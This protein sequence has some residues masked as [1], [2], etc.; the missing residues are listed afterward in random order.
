MNGQC[1]IKKYT[2]SKYMKISIIISVIFLHKIIYIHNMSMC[3]YYAHVIFF[4][5]LY[6]IYLK[7]NKHSHKL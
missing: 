2:I 7:Q 5:E 1:I 6:L 3:I 4:K